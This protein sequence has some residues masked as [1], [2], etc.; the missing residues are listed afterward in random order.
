MKL[1]M[2]CLEQIF[3][4]TRKN[5]QRVAG[6]TSEYFDKVILKICQTQ[7]AAQKSAVASLHLWPVGMLQP[8]RCA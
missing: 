1:N 7:R 6:T 4:I 3:K 8:A 2:F 5:T